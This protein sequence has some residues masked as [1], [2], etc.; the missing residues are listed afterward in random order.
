MESQECKR[1]DGLAVA[2]AAASLLAPASPAAAQA[3]AAPAAPPTYTL[4]KLD[5]AYDA[6]EPHIDAK[7][8]EIHHAKHHQTYIDKVNAALAGTPWEGKPVE[9]VIAHLADIPEDPSASSGQAPAG[10]QKY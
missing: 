3:A 4:P 8:M 2:G 9:E 7:T 6:L 1:M 5:Y 10:I